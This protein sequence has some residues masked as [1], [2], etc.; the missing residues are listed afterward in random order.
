MTAPYCVFQKP[1]W[2]ASRHLN[3]FCTSEC[4]KN[5]LK[6]CSFVHRCI[7]LL[8]KHLL[9]DCFQEQE[10]GEISCYEKWL[11]QYKS[12]F[13]LMLFKATAK[14]TL[15]LVALKNC[16]YNP[17][18]GGG[19]SNF[20]VVLWIF[21]GELETNLVD[22][23]SNDASKAAVRAQRPH[24]RN[25]QLNTSPKY[26]FSINSCVQKSQENRKKNHICFCTNI[27][28][29]V[30]VFHSQMKWHF[31]LIITWS[32]TCPENNSVSLLKNRQNWKWTCNNENNSEF[33]I[34]G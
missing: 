11:W 24:G 9:V 20:G 6:C 25:F 14:A 29:E 17:V 15:I 2:G 10:L 19:D 21:G 1:N 4:L 32:V 26:S 7:K 27:P 18:I 5:G 33:M 28:S 16:L 8:L 34:S 22:L 12:I 3:G 23:I 30:S 13:P 31:F